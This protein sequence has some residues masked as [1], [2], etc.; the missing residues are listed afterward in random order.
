MGLL[1]TLAVS[2]ALSQAAAGAA[3]PEG[4]GAAA[5]ERLKGLVGE[6]RGRRPDG[7]EVGV[8]YRLSAGGTVLVETWNLGPQRESLTI[9][10][11]DGSA[12]MAT[13]FCP[14]G[15]QPRLKLTR[16]AGRRFDFAFHDIT[17]LEPGKA[18]QHAFWIELGAD[19]KITRSETYLQGKEAETETITYQRVAGGSPTAS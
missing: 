5:F 7:R 18:F 2:L 9:Y 11:M 4:H 10:H 3:A 14:Q 15:N 19:G 12:L 8:T 6:W 17:G 13:H 1:T 16:A